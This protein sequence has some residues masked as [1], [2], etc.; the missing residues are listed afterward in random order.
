MYI[1][2]NFFF[3]NNRIF[4]KSM[5]KAHWSSDSW[6]IKTY[7]SISLKSYLISTNPCSLPCPYLRSTRRKICW[8]LQLLI[9]L[10]GDDILFKNWELIRGLWDGRFGIYWMIVKYYTAI[11]YTL[12]DCE[13]NKHGS[14]TYDGGRQTLCKG[15]NRKDVITRIRTKWWSSH[16]YE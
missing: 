14:R 11:P 7:Y 16:V 1:D 12:V 3:L 5:K 10:T 6:N 4:K 8:N 2:H 13:K 15:N 9:L